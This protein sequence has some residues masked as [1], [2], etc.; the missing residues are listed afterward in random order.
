MKGKHPQQFLFSFYAKKK[1]K[2][3]QAEALQT[4]SSEKEEEVLLSHP[5]ASSGKSQ[6]QSDLAKDNTDIELPFG[7]FWSGIDQLLS[8]SCIAFGL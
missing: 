5:H 4:D 1:K 7:P 3:R 6:Q 8:L 2:K